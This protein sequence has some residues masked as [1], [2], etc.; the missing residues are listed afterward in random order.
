MNVRDNTRVQGERLTNN[1]VLD[2]QTGIKVL[3]RDLPTEMEA[4]GG[5]LTVL[6]H[7]ENF[8]Q[9]L[10]NIIQ[11]P[12]GAIPEQPEYGSNILK[13][14]SASI[15]QVAG[16]MVA[17]E[18]QRALMTNPRVASVTGMTAIRDEDTYRIKYQ[19][20]PVNDLTEADLQSSLALA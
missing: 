19:V 7:T 11:T 15:P 4:E 6:Q 9:S 17:V 3:G 5:D 10:N 13:L 20:T 8:F 14:E 12:V 16:D 18:V 1:C 2:S